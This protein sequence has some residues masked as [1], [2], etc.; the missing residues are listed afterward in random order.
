MWWFDARAME[1]PWQLYLLAP[2]AVI[3]AAVLTT[4]AVRR[5]KLGVFLAPLAV[6]A[7]CTA[8]TSVSGE[9]GTSKVLAACEQK[10]RA[11][12]APSGLAAGSPPL[13]CRIDDSSWGTWEM[14][15]YSGDQ[16]IGRL[17]LQAMEGG[18]FD[19][20]GGLKSER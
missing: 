15:V 16:R 8:G 4:Y 6:L 14:G 1:S 18:F 20:Y 10:L 5:S 11:F 3:A 17:A 19:A 9:I 12:D 13:H 7:T 2:I